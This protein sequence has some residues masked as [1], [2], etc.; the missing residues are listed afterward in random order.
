MQTR[1][2]LVRQDQESCGPTQESCD[3]SCDQASL[4]DETAVLLQAVQT[5]AA[6]LSDAGWLDHWSHTAPC[7]LAQSWSS[8]HPHIPLTSL[9]RVTGLDFLLGDE[10]GERVE[11]GEEGE[12]GMSDIVRATETLDIAGGAVAMEAANQCDESHDIETPPT[13]DEIKSMWSEFYN[14]YYWHCYQLWLGEGEGEE[15]EGEGEQGEGEDGEV[16]EGGAG[17]GGG[18]GCGGKTGS[19]HEET[20]ENKEELKESRE[21]R[22]TRDQRLQTPEEYQQHL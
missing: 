11:E 1:T 13:D 7:L 2:K 22:W 18:K 20:E 19:E 9:H 21:K 14:S 17:C 15:G 5:K 12:E 16:G 4:E 8:L 6:A 3:P 10:S